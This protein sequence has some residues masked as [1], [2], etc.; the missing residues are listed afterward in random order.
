M[1]L[2]LTAQFAHSANIAFPFFHYSRD[3]N[4][5][6]LNLFLSDQQVAKLSFCEFVVNYLSSPLFILFYFVAFFTTCNAFHSNM[7]RRVQLSL[8]NKIKATGQFISKV[9]GIK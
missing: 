2:N 3:F 5:S 4:F 8:L 1:S 9:R 6:L 7:L